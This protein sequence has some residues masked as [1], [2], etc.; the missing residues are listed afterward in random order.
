MG[1]MRKPKVS[2]DVRKLAREVRS[3]MKAFEV[4]QAELARRLGLCE[5]TLSRLLNEHR[6]P[7]CDVL[8]T[9]CEWVWL[10]PLYFAKG[11]LR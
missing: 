8:L 4:S 11:E 5:S 3:C 1:T 10:G 9:I 2:L 7:S 6:K